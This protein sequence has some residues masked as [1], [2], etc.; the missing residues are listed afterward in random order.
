MKLPC[1]HYLVLAAVSLIGLRCT[2]LR[3]NRARS[4]FTLDNPCNVGHCDY[5]VMFIM[6]LQRNLMIIHRTLAYGPVSL[7]LWD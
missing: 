1:P 2:N 4:R 6:F 7:L 5:N 3:C